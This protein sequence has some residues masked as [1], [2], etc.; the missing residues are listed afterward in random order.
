MPNHRVAML[1]YFVASRLEKAYEETAAFGNLFP[2]SDK[3]VR[4]SG[5][6]VESLIYKGESAS[7]REVMIITKLLIIPLYY[8]ISI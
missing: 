1:D 2:N 7:H 5:V 6:E 4:R 3:I 8:K